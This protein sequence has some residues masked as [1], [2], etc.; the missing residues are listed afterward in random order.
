MIVLLNPFQLECLFALVDTPG[1]RCIELAVA[2]I[3]VAL[4]MLGGNLQS[5]IELDVAAGFSINSLYLVKEV[6]FFP[7]LLNV[8][9]HEKVLN[10]VR[11]SFCIEIVM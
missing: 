10:F 9:Y 5:F 6:P 3:L 11:C 4:L 7:T 8:F 1:R 2:H